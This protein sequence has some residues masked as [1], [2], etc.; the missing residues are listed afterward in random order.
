MDIVQ[1]RPL[2]DWNTLKV[3]KG[4]LQTSVQIRPLRDWNEPESY[5][6][7]DLYESSNQTFEGLKYI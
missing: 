1:I 6:V 4:I 3:E 5:D 7:I 2:R